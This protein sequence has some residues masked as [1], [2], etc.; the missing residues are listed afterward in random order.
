MPF[1]T[2]ES[3]N[4]YDA[5]VP[6]RLDKTYGVSIMI[7]IMTL[8][9]SLNHSGF[10]WT[11]DDFLQGLICRPPTI[12]RQ[13][14]LVTMAVCRSFAAIHVIFAFLVSHIDSS[15]SFSAARRHAHGASFNGSVVKLA[16]TTI[17]SDN[18]DASSFAKLCTQ[19]TPERNTPPSTVRQ[20]PC[21]RI[22][23]YNSDFYNGVVCIGCFREAFEIGNWASFAP[24]ERVYALQ[25]ALDRL[26]SLDTMESRQLE[27][28]VSQQ[29]LEEMIDYYRTIK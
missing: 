28:S 1:D 20:T 23:R 15:A 17:P 21:V 10:H 14:A 29:E 16:L 22:C 7:G 9:Y 25:D 2:I 26:E 27:G 24:T 18:D 6:R 11:F 19:D 12:M 5:S 4:Q 8:P 3:S 13:P